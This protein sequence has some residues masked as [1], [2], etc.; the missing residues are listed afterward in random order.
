MT[1]AITFEFAGITLQL[2]DSDGL[3]PLSMPVMPLCAHAMPSPE[4]VELFNAAMQDSTQKIAQEPQQSTQS[5]VPTSTESKTAVLLMHLSSPGS[6]VQPDDVTV[7]ASKT[8]ENTSVE[9]AVPEFATATETGVQK[10]V[11]ELDGRQNIALSTAQV[12]QNSPQSVGTVVTPQSS[13]TTDASPAVTPMPPTLPI[14]TSSSSSPVISQ[15]TVTAEASAQ[16]SPQQPTVVETPVTP[17]STPVVEM[18]SVSTPVAQSN[19]AVVEPPV[20]PQSPE[21]VIADATVAAVPNKAT[22]FADETDGAD[23][24]GV[25]LPSDDIA[26]EKPVQPQVISVAQTVFVSPQSAVSVETA[27]VSAASAASSFTS[28][29]INEIVDAVVAQIQV[30]PALKSGEETVR[31]YLKP[32]VLEGSEISLSAKSGSLSVE[33][34]PA[35]TQIVQKIQSALPQLEAALVGHVAEYHSISVSLRKERR[36]ETIRNPR[37]A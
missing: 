14:E 11:V 20:M 9:I 7:Q 24:S 23:D 22:V 18:P 33:I 1:D 12:Q 21:V 5:D 36:N 32:T 26:E 8:A 19:P 29:Q 17:T 4:A 16:V 27:T 2:P 25:V 30:E 3:Q 6:F 37:I 10:P 31:I 34:S 35:T 28:V 13:V 15:S